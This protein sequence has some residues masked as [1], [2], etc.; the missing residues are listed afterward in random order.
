LDAPALTTVG[1]DLSIYAQAKLDALTTVGGYLYIY[2]QAELDAPAL[3]TVGGYLYINAQA[4]LDAPALTTV[5]GDLSICAQA[6]LDAPALKGGNDNTAK[7]KCTKALELS[8]KT[9]GLIKIDGILSWLISRKKIGPLFA[10]K[11]KIVGKLTTSFAVQRGLLFSHG[12]TVEKAIESLRYKLQDRDTSRFEGWKL[13][14][15][16]SLDDAIQAYRAITGAC[17]YGVRIFCESKKIPEKLTIAKAIEI[18]AG[19]YGSAKF[20]AFFKK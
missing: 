19:S 15:K 8:L 9:K 14:T 18:T 13:T 1:G 2:A 20:A 10:F 16:V 5:G 4:E 17:E 12:E 6:K 3:T 11:V 7:A